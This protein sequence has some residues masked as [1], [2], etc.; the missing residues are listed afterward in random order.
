M[1]VLYKEGIT[2]WVLIAYLDYSKSVIEQIKFLR[3]KRI[4][5]CTYKKGGGNVLLRRAVAVEATYGRSRGIL[6]SC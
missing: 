2:G 1:N 6:V 5:N 4:V 3:E